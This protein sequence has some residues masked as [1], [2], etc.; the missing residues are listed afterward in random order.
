MNTITIAECLCILL[1]A[2]EMLAPEW[3]TCSFV[4]ILQENYNSETC[5]CT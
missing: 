5:I 1:D 3:N 2:L 4:I